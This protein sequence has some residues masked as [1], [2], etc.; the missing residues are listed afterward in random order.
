MWHILTKYNRKVARKVTEKEALYLQESVG[1]AV[2]KDHTPRKYATF[3]GE[4]IFG[5]VVGYV[6]NERPIFSYGHIVIEAD[7]KEIATVTRKQDAFRIM[8]ALKRDY[9]D[10]VVR[11]K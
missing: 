2:E 4:E 11:I 1:G 5:D 6:S 9:K 8:Q 3:Q 7:G 10:I